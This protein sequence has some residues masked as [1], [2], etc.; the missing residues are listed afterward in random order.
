MSVWTGDDLRNRM[1]FMR[2]LV[3]TM[4]TAKCLIAE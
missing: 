4:K 2:D 1:L 3:V